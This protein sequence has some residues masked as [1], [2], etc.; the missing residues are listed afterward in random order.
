M[1]KGQFA[2]SKT[3]FFTNCYLVVSERVWDFERASLINMV[4]GKKRL[5]D[6]GGLLIAT[7]IDKQTGEAQDGTVC[8]DAFNW[9]SA[10]LFCRSIGHRFSNWGSYPRNMKYVPE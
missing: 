3:R 9:Y 1:N 5:N 10:Q 7:V 8:K 6:N 2:L 4:K